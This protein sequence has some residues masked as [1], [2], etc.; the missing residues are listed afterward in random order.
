MAGMGKN[1]KMKIFGII[2][3]FFACLT[4]AMACGVSWG[5]SNMHAFNE[6]NAMGEV[7]IAEPIGYIDI[8]DE[9]QMD[10][11]INFNSNRRVASKTF[12]YGWWF[13]LTDSY[14][15]KDTQDSYKFVMPNSWEVILKRSYKNKKIFETK[16]K[17]WVLEEIPNG[18]S[19]S[20]SCGVM[21]IYKRN[22]LDQVKYSNGAVL[23]FKYEEGRL[24]QIN[25]KGGPVLSFRYE[26]DDTIYLDLIKEKRT[27]RFKLTEVPGYGKLLS[28]YADFP[29]GERIMKYSYNFSDN[30]TS[31][32]SI[33]QND[34]TKK[35]FWEHNTGLIVKEESYK[36]GKLT[37]TYE[38]TIVN[39]DEPDKY[40]YLKRK[41]NV[42]K[43]EDIFYMNDNG[44]SVMQKDSGDIV[45]I[46]NNMS[47][48]SSGK[49]RKIE[50]KHPDGTVEK[51]LFIYDSKGRI[52]REIKNGE[53]LYNIKRND[54][55]RSITYYD[56]NWK[57]I[58]KKIFDAQNR[59][60]SYE[61]SDGSKTTFRYLQ[62]GG[63]EATLTKN[64]KTITK[65]F[66][67]SL[68]IIK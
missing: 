5:V 19:V 14:V 13:G 66:N 27:I 34:E 62:D 2:V 64:G 61:K 51:Q 20:G 6:I 59:V 60:I 25:S 29:N 31:E 11:S 50:T 35:I 37:D 21:L 55:E 41:S 26:K 12:G 10:L 9:N 56:G 24:K 4:H 18:F 43:K 39:R 28:E 49:P 40:K 53:V 16:R 44:V 47:A 30:D 8:D 33:N 3:F 32:L 22:L 42:S 23:F 17:N 67:E 15:V 58:W 1:A 52:I 65:V 36:N 38:Y 7:D 48:N 45:K 63:I 68:S 46:Y 54:N 57:P